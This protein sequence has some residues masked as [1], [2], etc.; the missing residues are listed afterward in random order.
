[1]SEH[2]K[3][4][5]YVIESLDP[6]DEGNGRFEGV[7]LARILDLHGKRCKYEYVRTKAQFKSAV[8]RFGKSGYRYLHISAHANSDGMRTTNQDDI[9]FVEFGQIL[10]P[11]LKERRL[12]VSA[13]RMVHLDLAKA[14]IP[15]SGCFSVI[16]PNEDVYFGDAAILWSSLY[17]LMFSHNAEKMQRN[18]LVNFLRQTSK[19]FQV[20]MSYFSKST[21]TPSGVSEDLLEK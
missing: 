16:G 9:D 11:H 8:K 18:E 13:C 3:P 12:F 10:H 21:A 20:S 7:I 1:M 15:Q 14:V 17:H 19:L 2:T 5:V 6:N 4:E